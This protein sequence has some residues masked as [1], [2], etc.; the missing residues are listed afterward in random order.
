MASVQHGAAQ[1][2]EW[3]WSSME[4][5]GQDVGKHVGA[6][7]ED[8]WAALMSGDLV[9]QVQQQS[10]TFM[11]AAQEYLPSNTDRVLLWIKMHPTEAAALIACILA[12]P[13]AIAMTPAA[14]GLAGFTS[15]G[16]VAGMFFTTRLG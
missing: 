9:R 11:D 6:T 12:A 14:L 15:G 4:N 13:T 10:A 5:F 8:V 7:P 2:K 3:D 16:V 1:V